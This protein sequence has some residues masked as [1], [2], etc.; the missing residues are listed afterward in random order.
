MKTLIVSGSDE[1][2]M[3]MFRRLVSSLAIF[4]QRTKSAFAY[5]DLGLSESSKA[6]IDQY[7]TASANPKWDLPVAA[8]LVQTQSHL[9]ALTARPFL[10]DYFPGYDIYLWIDADAYVQEQFALDWLIEGASQR[11]MAIAA[12]VDCAYRLNSGVVRW[13]MD[14]MRRYFGKQAGLDTLWQTPFNAGVFAITSNAP[15]WASWETMFRLGLQT[16]GGGLVCDQ[17]ALN[18]ALWTQKLSLQ[19]LPATC[20]WLCHLAAPIYLES[21]G[22]YI[23][24]TLHGRSIGII[25]QAGNSKELRFWPLSNDHSAKTQMIV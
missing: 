10:R 11:Q 7:A 5:F 2:F 8:D 20:N 24:P 19:V 4:T 15:H 17:M 1:T 12:E 6:W 13:R 3:P 23:E 25:H 21:I 16:T 14:R 9:R 18:R 22:K